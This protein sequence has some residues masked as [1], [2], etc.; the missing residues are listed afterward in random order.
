MHASL[1]RIYLCVLIAMWVFPAAPVRAADV[2]A[3]F[4]PF[5]AC[6]ERHLAAERA[7]AAPSVDA[8]LKVCSAEHRAFQQALPPGA[9][10]VI[11]HHVR[12]SIRNMLGAP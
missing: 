9:Q 5:K 1:F 4:V 2:D 3:A 12:K 6:V 8:I 10:A 11:D 7:K